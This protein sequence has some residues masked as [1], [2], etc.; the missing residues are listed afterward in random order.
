MIDY[1]RFYAGAARMLE[2][3]STGE[4]MRDHTSVDPA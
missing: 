4:Y 2:G 1:V 3:R